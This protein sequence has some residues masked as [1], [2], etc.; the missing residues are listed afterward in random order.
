MKKNFSVNLINIKE[1]FRYEALQVVYSFIICQSLKRKHLKFHC[2][3][4]RDASYK[5][6][7]SIL[8]GF[9]AFRNK[10]TLVTMATI[11]SA[12]NGSSLIVHTVSFNNRLKLIVCSFPTEGTTWR[13][14]Y[15]LFIF[16]LK[17]F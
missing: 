1:M 14:M 16:I 17:P 4:L 6:K 9:Y 10:L 11:I 5:K 7:L 15:Y 3:L 12:A 2:L 13:K 8:Y